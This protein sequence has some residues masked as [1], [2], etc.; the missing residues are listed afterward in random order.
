MLSVRFICEQKELYQFQ[1]VENKSKKMYIICPNPQLADDIRGHI[2]DGS[3]VDNFESLTISKFVKDELAET[4][5]QEILLKR[6]QKADLLLILGS[7]FRT[8]FPDKSYELFL[9]GFNLY[10]EMRSFT[11]KEDLMD[12]ILEHYNDDLKKIFIIFWKIVENMG[13]IDEQNSYKELTEAYDSVEYE[14]NESLIDR[15]IVLFG[16]THLSG[17]QIDFIK[18]LSIKNNIY[19]PIP[20]SLNDSLVRYDWLS[21]LDVDIETKEKSMQHMEELRALKIIRFTKGRLHELLKNFFINNPPVNQFDTFLI[22]KGLSFY[23][24]TELPFRNVFFKAKAELFSSY[25][26]LEFTLFKRLLEKVAFIEVDQLVEL[27]INKI[28]LEMEKKT[29]NKNFRK[30]KVFSLIKEEFVNYQKQSDNNNTVRMF[31]LKLLE[32]ICE[33]RLPRN[34]LVPIQSSE[35][36]VQ[37]KG[38]ESLDSSLVENTNYLV[39]SS[40]YKTIKDSDDPFPE[41]VME[42]LRAY[43]PVRRNR[44]EIEL[45]KQK[46]G[47]LLS[48]K[49]T[50]LFLEDGFEKSD[51]FWEEILAKYTHENIKLGEN[52]KS[53]S[54]DIF[55]S[56]SLKTHFNIAQLSP[57]KLQTYIDCP[58]KFFIEYIQKGSNPPLLKTHLLPNQLGSLEH[59]IIEEY[60]KFNKTW[61]PKVHEDIVEIVLSDY[62][63]QNTIC[64][65]SINYKKNT[66]ELRH[67]TE[68]VINLLLKI[69]Q[70]F[71][72]STQFEKEVNS[73]INTVKFYGKVDCII[74]FGDW[75]GVFDFKRSSA[76]VPTKKS[77]LEYEKVQLWSYLRN[78]SLSK[79]VKLFGYLNLKE[80]KK[81]LIFKN[82]CDFEF[83]E[84]YQI[85]LVDLVE[86]VSVLIERYKNIEDDLVARILSDNEF[87]VHP[88]NNNVCT[89]CR[90][91]SLCHRGK[92]V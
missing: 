41:E 54:I 90:I 36:K 80:L 23:Q 37:I 73:T 12:E 4:F 34:F 2:I 91:S 3:E 14:H 6:I 39:G 81:S 49:N 85:K 10:T 28:K 51:P 42:I 38:I 47:E 11:L 48:Q 86:E 70:T 30:L 1:F 19:I 26:K 84:S 22:G 5:G 17:T 21:W 56:P 77:V 74:D 62:I 88:A 66:D 78:L 24:Y 7:A 50:I 16:F 13:L 67:L 72:A 71:S 25:L 53:E 15:E 61:S 29:N 43:G 33:L 64:L 79:P 32:N 9:N 87:P 31:E 68:G 92:N 18:A 57:S 46:I 60:F 20:S 65:D 8:M 27:I 55:R 40:D 75:L 89:Y 82:G 76:S 69:T 59:K 52:S 44:I 63:S 83:D 35:N 58:K 45:V